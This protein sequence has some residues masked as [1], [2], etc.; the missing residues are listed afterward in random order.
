MDHQGS[1]CRLLNNGHSA[2]CEVVPHCSFD[3]H[4]FLSFF[5]VLFSFGSFYKENIRHRDSLLSCVQYTNKPII[6]I[7]HIFYSLLTSGILSS[8]FEFPFLKRPI[9]CDP[10]DCSMPDFLCITNSQLYQTLIN[11]CIILVLY[12]QSGNYNILVIADSGFEVSFLQIAFRH[13][14]CCVI[15]S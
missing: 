8:F 5:S 10:V 13:L 14:V 9:L 3:L 2:W 6:F 15:F 4:F 7:L 12:F 1:P 11:I